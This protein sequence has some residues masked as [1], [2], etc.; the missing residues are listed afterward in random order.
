[1]ETL[2]VRNMMRAPAPRPEPDKPGAF[3]PNNARAKAGLA[4]SL[5]DASF[6][7]LLRMLGYKTTWY[8][9][10]I[11]KAGRWMPSSKTCSG[12]GSVKAKLTLAE[13]EFTCTDCGLVIDRD[14]NAATN[15]ARV[16]LAG[17]TTGGSG[18]LDTGG[19]GGKTRVRAHGNP[20]TPDPA[21]G[22]ETGTQHAGTDCP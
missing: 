11:V 12:C 3:L 6:G 16:A 22:C 15:L 9:S 13:R 17:C 2:A 20:R 10:R 18:P 8:G 1:M 4:R 21:R 19:A 5:A 7:A 14:L